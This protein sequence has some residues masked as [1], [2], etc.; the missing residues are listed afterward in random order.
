MAKYKVMVS[1]ELIPDLFMNGTRPSIKVTNGLPDGV[2]L[3]G[4]DYD[5]IADI[6]T[7]IFVD[8]ID[9]SYKL[10]EPIFYAVSARPLDE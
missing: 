1:A 4:V 9:D 8:K 5:A 2:M 6:V 7:F 10:I 3:H